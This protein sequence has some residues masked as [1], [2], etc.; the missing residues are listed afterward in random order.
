[1]T[2][3]TSSAALFD[4]KQTAET[5]LDRPLTAQ[6]GYSEAQLTAAETRLQCALPQ[7]LREF[8][9]LV[10]RVEMFTESFNYF[11]EPD[12]LTLLD[13]KILFLEENQSVCYWATDAQN[14]VWQTPDAKKLEWFAEENTLP[15]FLEILLYYQLAQGGY[16]HCGM[17][18]SQALSNTSINSKAVSDIIAAYD[19]PLVID[20][21]Q[22]AIYAQGS[23]LLWYLCDA[24][25]NI[26]PGIFTCSLHQTDFA[27]LLKKHQFDDLG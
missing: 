2:T 20:T 22:L 11:A 26:N 7:A 23:N 19:W 10:G 9:A 12:E 24:K 1:M 3:S 5:L 8:Y 21:P 15:D 6:D 16:P 18:V 25:G 13:G 27:A 17:V 14:R 4:L